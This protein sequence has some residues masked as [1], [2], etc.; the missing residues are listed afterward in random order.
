M[1]AVAAASLALTGCGS[2]DEATTTEKP[3]GPVTIKVWA[4]Y[5]EFQGVVDLFNKTHSDIKIE[6]TNAGAGQDQY[7]KLQTALKAGKGAP[8]VAMLELQEIP[9]FQL[10]K[11]LVD[12][13]KYGANDVKGDYVEWAWKQVS[14]GD[15]VYAIPVDAGPMALLYRED[16]FKQYGLTVP[17][18]WDEYKQQAEK[19]KAASGG[20]AFMTD[21]GANDGGFLTGL[22]WQAGAKPYA[23]DIADPSKIG[24]N[25]N[26]P[27]AK[28]VVEYWEGMVNGGLADT[29]AYGTTDFYNGLGSGKYVTY[30]SAGW[31]PGYLQSIAEKTKGKWKAVPLP[32]WTAGANA[33]GDWGGSSF[34]VTDQAK[35]PDIAAKVA[36]ELFGAKNTDAWKIGIDKAYL[37]P[38]A[39]P[40]LE[41]DA[42]MKKEYE[43]FGGQ[44][45]NEVFVPAYNAIGEFAWS[46][47]NSYNFNQI[48]TGL[49]QAIEKKTPWSAALDTAQENI[50]TYATQQ[51]FK[52]Q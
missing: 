13:G 39:T 31:G 19:L 9:T 33:Q 46:P 47:F 6:W 23:Y 7:T 2:G 24:V 5:P 22:M 20:K 25:V 21:F 34:A 50:K 42:F 37:F 18:T 16:L 40:I 44:K 52:V 3:T 51:G 30:I 1:A 45:V 41:S 12:L 4:W 8:D 49:N 11:H 43:F 17:T 10:T 48:T 28:K 35:Y 29:K 15:S 38:T 26:S 14:T 27:E 32:Q 36:M